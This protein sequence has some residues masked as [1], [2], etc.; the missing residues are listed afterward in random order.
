LR[1]STVADIQYPVRHL[2]VMNFLGFVV[3][4]F[5]DELPEEEAEG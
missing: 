4:D 1:F 2:I 3:A 5:F